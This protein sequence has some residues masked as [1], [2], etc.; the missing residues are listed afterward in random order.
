MRI[1][2]E[3]CRFHSKFIGQLVS[4]HTLIWSETYFCPTPAVGLA[5]YGSLL[6]LTSLGTSLSSYSD[7]L[8]VVSDLFSE[9]G[10]ETSFARALCA[11]RP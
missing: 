1:D 11:A 2:T 10:R 8:H 3:A 5:W 6:L 9:T 7:I 4:Q